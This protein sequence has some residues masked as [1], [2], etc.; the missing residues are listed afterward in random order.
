MVSY[1]ISLLSVLPTAIEDFNNNNSGNLANTIN[2]LNKF[3]RRKPS[4]FGDWHKKLA[5]IQG[6]TGQTRP[7]QKPER[8]GEARAASE[9]SIAEFDR[10]N[11]DLYTI[12]YLLTDK[13]TTLLVATHEDTGTSGNNGQQAPH[14]LV[15]KYKKITDEVIRPTMD[16]LMYIR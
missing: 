13:P 5:V 14:E 11:K 15:K 6:V 16:K 8:S 4:Q 7:T 10:A 2:G 9:K 3:D 1:K 12:L